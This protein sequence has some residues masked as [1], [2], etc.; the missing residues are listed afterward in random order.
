[1]RLRLILDLDGRD[2][3]KQMALD[4]ALLILRSKD[5][6]PDTLRLWVFKPSAVSIG[7]F[8]SIYRV[9]DLEH[10][11]A[12]GVDVVRR[13]TGGGAVY[14]EYGGEL[15]YTVA[16]RIR[17]PLTDVRK[18]YEILCK[19]IIKAINILGLPAEF[20]PVNDVTVR[21]KKI[22]GSAQARRG[23]ALLQHGTLMY[24]TDLDKLAQLLRPPKEKLLA[25][26]VTGIR[27]RVTTL[28]IELQKELSL[29]EVVRAVIQGFAKSL[30]AEF[31]EDSLHEEELKLAKELE[32]KYR[33]REW[34]YR[35]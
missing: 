34:L 20:K 15:T 2:A 6:I 21:G 23:S 12:L 13:F 22:S 18:S 28:S 16:M 35:R 19:G 32:T 7:Y 26:G 27:Q 8:Q 25:H 14:H 24:A 31:Y 30:G 10:A 4:E 29:D 1:M 33:S 11:K 9:V 3:F 5:R 17:G